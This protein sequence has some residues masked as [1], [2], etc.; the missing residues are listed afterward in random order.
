MIKRYMTMLCGADVV[1]THTDAPAAMSG[2]LAQQAAAPTPPAEEPPAAEEPPVVQPAPPAAAQQ[3]EVVSGK[4]GSI[5]K[6]EPE[7]VVP[8]RPGPGLGMVRP[9]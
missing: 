6:T 5:T 8:K 4:D 1:V 2:T 7:T 9:G 3:P